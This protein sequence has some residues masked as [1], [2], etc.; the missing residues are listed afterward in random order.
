MLLK[1]LLDNVLILVLVE[2]TLGDFVL[3]VIEVLLS[4]LNPCFSGTY[5]RSG[6]GGED[7]WGA[8]CVLILVLVEHTLG[9]AA[10]V[11]SLPQKLS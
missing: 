2:H 7:N 5:S 4:S 8:D 6:K 9:G 11:V 1:T 10:F 3:E